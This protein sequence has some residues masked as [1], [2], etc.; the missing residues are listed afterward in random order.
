MRKLWSNSLETG[1]CLA[2]MLLLGSLPN[3]TIRFTPLN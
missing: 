3:Y 2:V 1:V